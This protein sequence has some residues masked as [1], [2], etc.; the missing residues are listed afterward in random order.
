VGVEVV[1]KHCAEVMTS[2]G[3]SRSPVENIGMKTDSFLE[4]KNEVKICPLA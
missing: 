1:T 3:S 2:K 4:E